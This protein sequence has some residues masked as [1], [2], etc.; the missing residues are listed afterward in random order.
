VGLVVERSTAGEEARLLLLCAV[1][2]GVVVW[3]CVA[4]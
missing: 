1:L 2:L 4:L 3:G